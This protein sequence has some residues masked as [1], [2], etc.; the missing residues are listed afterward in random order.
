MDAIV[1]ARALLDPIPAHRSLGLEVVRAADGVGV[2][3]VESR[4]GLANVIGSLHSSG[5]M[6]LIDAAALA[7]II[8]AAPAADAFDGIVPLGAAATVRFRA[9]ARGRLVATCVLD[10]DARGRLAALLGGIGQRTRISTKSEVA[11]ETGTV[12]CEGTFDWSIRRTTS[13]A[14][15]R[16]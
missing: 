5:L 7:A 1:L 10:D 6:A 13:P 14:A 11:D 8:A 3:S 15:T 2:V 4:P 12:V 16:S 9:P